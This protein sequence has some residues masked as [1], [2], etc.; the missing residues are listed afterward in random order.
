ME[1]TKDR[2][3][4]IDMIKGFSM[5]C[6]ILGHLLPQNYVLQCIVCSF[7]VPIYYIISGFLMKHNE[8]R[9][10]KDNIKTTLKKIVKNL[11][12]PY[13]FFSFILILIA[14]LE[15]SY[16]FAK[17]L[18]TVT[19]N[20]TGIAALWFIPSLMITKV[21]FTGI[22]KIKNKLVQLLAIA[23]PLIWLFMQNELDYYTMPF[24]IYRSFLTTA[25]FAIG[26]YAYDWIKN[27]KIPTGILL[28][29][30][31][32]ALYIA[33]KNGPFALY[34][35]TSN[36]LILDTFLA[37]VVS[38]CVILLFKKLPQLKLLSFCGKNSIVLLGTHQ[39]IMIYVLGWLQKVAPN[40]KEILFIGILAIM[41]YFIIYICN[42]YLP[43]FIRKE[44]Y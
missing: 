33:C 34:N 7:H 41:E 28:L 11:L 38:I 1:E 43:F 16:S 3:I 21:A 29:A 24:L 8:I 14:I 36:C 17:A 15:G 25:L 20:F 32:M 37:I 9:K 31:A 23:I 40:F 12:V 30:I 6:I 44:K 22:L 27:V 2:I 19:F 26:Y 5:I 4:Y 42:R 39:I 35:L 18:A 13:F 10:G